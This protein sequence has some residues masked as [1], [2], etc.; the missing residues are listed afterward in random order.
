MS[1][2]HCNISIDRWWWYLHTLLVLSLLSLNFG[3]LVNGHLRLVATTVSYESNKLTGILTSRNLFY[4]TFTFLLIQITTSDQLRGLHFN[5]IALRPRFVMDYNQL[6][7]L[8]VSKIRYASRFVLSLWPQ[9]LSLSRT[10]GQ[11][12]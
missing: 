11:L 2:F 10:D 6:R 7:D 8:L 9:R 12:D 1:D 3:F 5:T 4:E